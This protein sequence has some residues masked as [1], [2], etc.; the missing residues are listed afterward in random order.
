MS[1]AINLIKA[2]IEAGRDF[3]R[4]PQE[5]SAGPDAARKSTPLLIPIRSLGV[6]HRER[7]AKHLLSL[8]PQDRYLRFG[9]LAQDEHIQRYVE[10]L[11]FERDEIFGIYN[12]KLELIAMAHLAHQP[13]G[14]C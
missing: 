6:N 3:L 11:D 4:P 10:K 13:P 14:L 9:Y 2:S 8:D 5:E 7:I 12:R 1:A